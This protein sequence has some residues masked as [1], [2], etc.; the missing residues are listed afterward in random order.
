MDSKSGP[1]CMSRF[2][3]GEHRPL[4]YLRMSLSA[5]TMDQDSDHEAG[6]KRQCKC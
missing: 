2:R 5:P 6:A 3:L 1:V 4:Y